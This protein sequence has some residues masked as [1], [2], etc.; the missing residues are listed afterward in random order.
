MIR[1]ATF[2]DIDAIWALRLKTSLLLHKRGIDQWQYL[3]PTKKRFIQD[4]EKESFFVY[5]LNEK[6]VGM[7]YMQHE[8]E[9]TYLHINGRWHLD[10]SYLTIHRLAIDD[11]YLGQG[12]SNKLMDYAKIYAKEHQINYIRIDTHEDN[13]HAVRLF[14]DHGFKLCGTIL[15]DENHQGDRKRL[16]FDLTLGDNS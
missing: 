11:A 3:N 12:L 13:K 9:S 4:I 7:M 5:E 8:I 15:L 2:D 10:K 16:A 1:K 6:I 14:T